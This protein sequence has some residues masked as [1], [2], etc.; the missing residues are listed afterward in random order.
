[1]PARKSLDHLDCAV[2]NTVDL[3]GDRWT[4][5]ILRD[6]F[7]G[8][9]RFDDFQADLGIA[10]NVLSDRLQMLV[11]Q[12]FFKTVQYQ[13]K[14][15]RFEYRLTDK[16]RDLL[17]VLLALWR[18]GDTWAQSDETRVAVHE[19]CGKPTHMVPVCQNCGEVL[20]RHNLTVEPLLPVVERRLASPAQ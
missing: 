1:M 2:A 3:L 7:F 15:T 13:E 9:R 11:S 8:V 10:R 12:G 17:P 6:A 19:A 18:F 5:L 4:L 20:T 14:P 16:G